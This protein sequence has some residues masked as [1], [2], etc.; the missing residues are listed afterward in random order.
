MKEA[1]SPAPTPD[2]QGDLR[3]PRMKGYYGEMSD[4]MNDILEK[5][6]SSKTDIME[7]VFINRNITSALLEK[8][9]E[10]VL[11]VNTKGSLVSTNGK[12]KLLMLGVEEKTITQTVKE[13]SESKSSK[14]SIAGKEFEIKRIPLISEAGHNI[15]ELISLS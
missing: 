15:G 4:L 9:P 8:Y 7:S 2:K 10:P 12:A 14:L 5:L 6:E 13:I 11:V 3:L 1:P